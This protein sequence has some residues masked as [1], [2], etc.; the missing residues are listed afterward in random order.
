M[1]GKTAIVLR[2][3]P[4]G[5]KTKVKDILLRELRSTHFVSLDDGWGKGEV[6]FRG[7]D[8]Y[9]DLRV[10]ADALIIELGFGEPVGETSAGATRDPSGWLR[11]LEDEGR[12]MHLFLLK[13]PLGEVFRR[14]EHDRNPDSQVYF[15]CAALRYEPN[16]VCSAEVFKERLGGA[17]REICVDTSLESESETARRIMNAIGVE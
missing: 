17:Y 9:A 14:I 4:C 16:G 8:P 13:P 15:R 1:A 11:V 3:P 2:G 10:N 7:V 5:G 12:T 6:R